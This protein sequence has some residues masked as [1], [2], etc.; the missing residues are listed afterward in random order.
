[1][2]TMVKNDHFEPVFLC[3]SSKGPGKGGTKRYCSLS[4]PYFF[5]YTFVP[6]TGSLPPS[7]TLARDR[8]WEVKRRRRLSGSASFASFTGVLHKGFVR[9]VGD[10]GI[11]GRVPRLSNFVAIVVRPSALPLPSLSSMW[12]THSPPGS[13]SVKIL[14]I[15]SELA[16]HLLIKETTTNIYRNL[17]RGYWI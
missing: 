16:W 9:T 15:M 1:M 6:I 14:P 17:P 10:T 8:V 5:R 13:Q 11:G 3:A 2:V 7:R 4:H 12:A